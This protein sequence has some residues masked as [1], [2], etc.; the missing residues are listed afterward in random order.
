MF[1]HCNLINQTNTGSPNRYYHY[2]GLYNVDF[3]IAPFLQSVLDSSAIP[4]L[5]GVKFISNDLVDLA[6]ATA[7]GE[8]K[9][10]LVSTLP[11]VKSLQ[12]KL[13]GWAWCVGGWE[14]FVGGWMWCLG[15]W[16][17]CVGGWA[18]CLAG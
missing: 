3:P 10:D 6:N 4:S 16:A 2:P 11:T 13:A 7:V 15:G 9:Y 18:W 1:S 14:W 17:C 5:Q 8:G 12:M